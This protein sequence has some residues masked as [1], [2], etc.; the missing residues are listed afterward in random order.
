MFY[1]ESFATEDLD[2]FFPLSAAT[3]NVFDIL[4]PIYD[5]LRKPGYEPDGVMV[6]IEAWPV[7][8]IPS[9]KPLVEQANETEYYQTPV[10]VMRSEHLVAIMLD[11]GRPKDYARIARFLDAATVDMGSLMDILSRHELEN[12]WRDNKGK[13][14]I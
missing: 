3:D 1:I 11:T 4:S 6:N 5:Y 13:F 9:Y 14:V 12:K 7:Q 10:Q 8:F 2:I